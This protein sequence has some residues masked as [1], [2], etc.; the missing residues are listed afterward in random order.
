MV[1]RVRVVV[2][3]FCLLKAPWSVFIRAANHGKECRINRFL[4][5]TFPKAENQLGREISFQTAN[6]L[7][8]ASFQQVQSLQ[9]F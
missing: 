1:P 3:V 8:I 7:R 2:V 4:S 5:L 9:L 6:I